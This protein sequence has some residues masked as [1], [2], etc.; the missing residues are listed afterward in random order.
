MEDYLRDT[1]EI[2]TKLQHQ[3]MYTYQA[4]IFTI[5]YLV[6]PHSG[7]SLLVHVFQ[8]GELVLQQTAATMS[9]DIFGYPD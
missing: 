6:Y 8:L 4:Q 5:L 9:E 1:S 2:R 7:K 3:S